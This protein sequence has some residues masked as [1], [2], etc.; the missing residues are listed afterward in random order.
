MID[1]KDIPKIKLPTKANYKRI[2]KD[3]DFYEVF[4]KI[5]PEFENCFI[6]ES[7]GEQNF[8]SRYS[9][10]GFDPEKIITATKNTLQIDNTKYEVENPY[11][12]LRAITP[13]NI[14]SR[15]YSGGLV[16]YMS[17]ESMNYFEKSLKLDEHPDFG[18]FKFG[19]YT[20]GLVY[21]KMT[22]EIFYYYFDNDRSNLINNIISNKKKISLPNTSVKYIKDTLSETE[23]K[24]AVEYVIEE[25][26]KGNTFQC[27]VGFKS[28]F[29]IYGDKLPIYSKLREINPSPHMYYMKFGENRIIGASPELLL[30]MRQGEMET[31]PLAGTAKRGKNEKEDIILARKL[32]NNPK[33]IAEH[34]M[35]I[36]L[37]R[38][39]LGRV[40]RFGT[41]KVRS[42]M[43]IKKFSHVQHISSEIAG[44]IKNE[45]D[46]FS[47]LASV[48]PAGTLTGAPKIES[49]KI[50]QHL[51]KSPR[52]PYGG[53]LGQLGFNGDCTVAIPIRTLFVTGDDAYAQTCGGI[54]YD[55]NPEDEYQE[56]VNKL[57]AMKKVLSEFEI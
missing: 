47:A 25:I 37:H 43:D 53:A 36:D 40:A 30:R 23:H 9:V 46:M 21:D 54:V 57:A 2:A 1:V 11:E 44:I 52:G 14:I 45:E 17:Y 8:T 13:Q 12:A 6:L 20:D 15:N 41:V 28:L 51:E 18:M 19:V 29:K 5:E 49:M 4:Q 33:E 10:I 38:N 56:I 22:G 42:S 32:L 26:K 7:L 35:L 55:S 27:E 31:F 34:S 3:I 16:G 48:F 50:I 39:D 24:K